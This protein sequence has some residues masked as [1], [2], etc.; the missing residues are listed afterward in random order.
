LSEELQEIQGHDDVLFNVTLKSDGIVY[1]FFHPETEIDV[2]F[3]EIL[4]KAYHK[5]TGGKKYPFLFEAADT[6]CV[7]KE[8]RENAILIE[9]RSPVGAT[10]IMVDNIANAL[11]ANFYLKFNKPKH[12]YKVFRN[13][14]EAVKWLLSL[15][16]DR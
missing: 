12:P 3:Q 5:V 1:V 15:N 7:T 16:I 10:A 14:Q 6:V 4:L 8:A 11:I 2:D 9:N 13:R